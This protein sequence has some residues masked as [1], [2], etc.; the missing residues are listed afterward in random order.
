MSSIDSLMIGINAHI[1]RPL[2]ILLF[3]IAI[4]LFFWGLAQ[5][6]L[7]VGS[8]DGRTTGKR[9]M[10]WSVIGLFI[11]FGV[12][13]ILVILTNTFGVDLPPLFPY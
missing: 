5:F 7:N 9:H 10:L 11:M 6:I 8:E 1:I 2:L 13:G 3:A 4:L 12:Y